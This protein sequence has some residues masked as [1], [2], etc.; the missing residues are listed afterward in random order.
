[1]LAAYAAPAAFDAGAARSWRAGDRFRM[2]VGGPKGSCWRG[3][4][5]A[6]DEGT[7]GDPWEALEVGRPCAGK[8]R[9]Q[10]CDGALLS[11]RQLR[12]PASQ[13]PSISNLGL[14]TFRMTFTSWEAI[15]SGH[16]L[17]NSVEHMLLLRN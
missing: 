3:T 14:P 13:V 5:T 6:A 1:V 15:L 8:P 9:W 4:I 11:S 10:A 16:K 2:Q 12:R 17:H 7:G